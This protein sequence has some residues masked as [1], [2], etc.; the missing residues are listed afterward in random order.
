MSRPDRAPRAVV[1][2][3]AGFIGSTLCE[4]LVAEG[5]RVTGVD[6][7]TDA[8][9]REDKERNLAALAG[10]PGFDLVEADLAADELAP[11]LAKRPAVVHLAARP[12]VRASF[13][14]GFPACLRD[15]VGATQRLLD[16]CLT[17]G[18]H[19]VVW[20]S[21][22]SVYGDTGGSPAHETRTPTVPLSPY[23]VSKRACEDLARLARGR[24]LLTVG[25]RFFTVY[26]P[27]QRPDMALRR[28]CEALCGGPPF[29]LLGDGAQARDLT[30]VDDAVEAALRALAAP[31]P[32]ELYNVGGG[33]PVSLR[34]AMAL[35]ERIAG[36]PVPLVRAGSAPGD[37]A[38]T[39]ADTIRARRDLGW[40]PMVPVARGLAGQLRWVRRVAAAR[41]TA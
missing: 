4:A 33:R 13:G 31:A 8:Y 27:R 23:A 36:A 14:E 20:A 32:A 34:E 25:L 41:L 11:L 6:A 30:H 15:N 2:G 9:P 26:G 39:A 12:G 29:R 38:V 21:S 28:M 40:R 7:F 16:A 22:S 18:A 3:C 1:T 17:A 37:V 35:L 10:D 24:G 19:R 5:W